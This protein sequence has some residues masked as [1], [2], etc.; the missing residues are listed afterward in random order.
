MLF[1]F[2]SLKGL[3]MKIDSFHQIQLGSVYHGLSPVSDEEVKKIYVGGYVPQDKIRGGPDTLQMKQLNDLFSVP[4]ICLLSQ[5]AEFF[6]RNQISYREC[7]IHHL[8]KRLFLPLIPFYLF[9]LLFYLSNHVQLA[10]SFNVSLQFNVNC[11][12]HTMIR[13]LHQ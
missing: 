2:F 7:F 6:S 10:S 8:V 1:V 9:N 5:V 11:Y 13:L 4:E 3:L 12:Q